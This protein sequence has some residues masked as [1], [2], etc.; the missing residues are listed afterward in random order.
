MNQMLY[1]FKKEK[2]GEKIALYLSIA[3]FWGAIEMSLPK[4]VP[5][6]RLGLANLALLMALPHLKIV[7]FFLLAFLKSLTV[8]ILSGR[9]FSPL[10]FLSLSGTIASAVVMKVLFSGQHYFSLPAISTVSAVVHALVQLLLAHWIYFRE[11]VLFFFFPMLLISIVTGFF[12]GCFACELSIPDF[13]HEWLNSQ[14]TFLPASKR[15]IFIWV[16]F[17]FVGFLGGFLWC[18][19]NDVLILTLLAFLLIFSQLIFLRN[20]KFFFSQGFAFLL[21]FFINQLFP[22][23]ELFF[24]WGSFVLADRSFELGLSKG[25]FFTGLIAYSQILF[26]LFRGW[27][28]LEEPFSPVLNHLTQFLEQP[29]RFFDLFLVK[30][31]PFR[32]WLERKREGMSLFVAPKQKIAKKREIWLL[33][34]LLALF[35]IT[36]YAENSLEWSSHLLS[37]LRSLS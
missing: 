32:K 15:T 33:F 3:L 14:E 6:F 23:G 11:E 13:S 12:L 1:Y 10:F 19:I 26:Y 24:R 4:V 34:F 29:Q 37:F 20:R 35:S 21:I 2:R 27:I 16:C 30:D 7:D 25:A 22:Q 8:S 31:S 17:L 9:L 28:D 5:F 36:L 18:Q